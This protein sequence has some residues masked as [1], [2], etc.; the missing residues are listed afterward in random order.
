ME[1]SAD[2][3]YTIIKLREQIR[4]RHKAIMDYGNDIATAKDED[5]EERKVASHREYEKGRY[6][7]ESY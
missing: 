4:A 6:S 2:L 1:S 7:R 3:I 5:R